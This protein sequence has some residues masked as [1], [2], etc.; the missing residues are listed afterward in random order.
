MKTFL[1]LYTCTGSPISK[2]HIVY[3]SNVFQKLTTLI[4]GMSVVEYLSERA[5][6]KFLKCVQ[7][8]DHSPLHIIYAVWAPQ[9]IIQLLTLRLPK[10]QT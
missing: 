4:F 3:V 1:G 10:I 8:G 2:I 5:F 7:H 6:D 9:P